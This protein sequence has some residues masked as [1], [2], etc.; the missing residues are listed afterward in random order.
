MLIYIL[1]FLL[2]ISISLHIRYIIG[3]VK[4]KNKKNFILFIV[5]ALLNTILAL[6]L[7]IFAYFNPGEI[8]KLNLDFI[9]WVFSG[10]IAIGLLFMKIIIFFKIKHRTKNPNNYHKNFFGKKV[11]H[12]SIIKK[13]EFNALLLSIPFFLISGAYFVARLINLILHGAL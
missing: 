1:F 8:Q 2:I 13:N 6:T 12:E 3:Y 4:Q 10:L 5:T 7:S 11:Y 9:L